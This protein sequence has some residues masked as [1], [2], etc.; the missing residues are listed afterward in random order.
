MKHVFQAGV[1]K[2][3]ELD[4]NKELEINRRR[5]STQISETFARKTR[6]GYRNRDPRRKHSERV[7][8]T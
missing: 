8:K 7:N 2:L 1:K 6:A 3:A 4:E 5:P